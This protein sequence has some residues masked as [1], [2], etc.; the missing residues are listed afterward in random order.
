MSSRF[1]FVNTLSKSPQTIFAKGRYVVIHLSH[2]GVNEIEKVLAIVKEGDA[3]ITKEVDASMSNT[4]LDSI[5]LD[6][7]L[8]L[9]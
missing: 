2:I 8:S 9:E 6:T 7:T 3:S 5:V 4:N 1:A